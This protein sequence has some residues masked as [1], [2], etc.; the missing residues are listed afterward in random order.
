[1]DRKTYLNIW[2][3]VIIIGVAIG[4]RAL[5][6]QYDIWY[7]E[8]CSWFTAIQS[9]PAGIMDNL[10]HLDIQHTPLY[11]FLLHF[12]IKLFGDGEFA[13]RFLSFVFG[14][15]TV[16]MVYIVSKKITSKQNSI[17]SAAIVAVA[18]LLVFFSVEIRMYPI[19]TFLV[20][21]ALNYLIDFEQKSDNK[22]L[23]KLVL[24]NLLIPYTFVGGIFYNLS[25][26]FC[27]GIYLF[28]NNKEKF[29]S[30]IKSV[31][32]ELVLLIPYFL[33]VL[34]YGKMRSIFV[35]KREGAFYFT[36]LVDVIRNFFGLD[37]VINIYW[38]SSDLYNLTLIFALLVVVP[39]TYFMY[40]YIQGL[41]KSQS[42]NKILYLLI[43]MI[44]LEFTISAMCQVSIFTS[45]YILYVLPVF[46]ILAVMGLSERV[47]SLHLKVFAVLFFLVGIFINVSYSMKVPTYRTQAYKSVRI[48]ADKLSLDSRDMVILPF[49]AD[50]PYYFRTKNSPRVLPFD[51][52]KEVRNP[53]NPKF[54]D[55][56]QQ[57]KIKE[58]LAPQLLYDSVFSNSGFSDAHFNY[59]TTN[60]NNTVEKGRYVLIA[61]YG[62][63]ADAVVKIED[64]RK[65]VTSVTD[66]EDRIVE[67]LLKKYLLD[68]RAYL[69]IDFY[70]EKAWSEDNYTYLLMRKK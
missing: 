20:M 21:L 27:Y 18:P 38:P 42:F 41:K 52:H 46:F 43:A 2:V 9:F 68:I 13:L 25:L 63:D 59:F 16:P 51:F 39:C 45:R 53:Y 36:H 60:V 31:G 3:W 26:F 57:E 5:F 28:K 24:A 55:D 22:S 58:G 12:W 49:G 50:A 34:Y 61:L 48:V 64:L 56:N 62:T 47:S 69:D 8:A 15:A 17:L 29:M 44:L 65:S 66:V 67:I 23:V 7:D 11:F 1:M 30:Y 35:I 40:G 10:L 14:V 54:Y 19:V 4:L 32:V 70:F 33:M 37:P 6:L